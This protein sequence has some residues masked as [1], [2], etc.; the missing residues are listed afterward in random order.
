V[1]DRVCSAIDF[2]LSPE[3]AE[4]FTNETSPAFIIGGFQAMAGAARA[5]DALTESFRA[6]AG[7]DWDR[8]HH[9]L[10]HGTERSFRPG[11]Q[12]NLVARGCWRSPGLTLPHRVC[13]IP[14]SARGRVV[15]AGHA[16]Q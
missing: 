15:P 9:D 11:C 7:L 5:V 14:R 2:S 10:F 3:Q 4:A 16:S 8:H 6:G 1:A 13:P 12:A